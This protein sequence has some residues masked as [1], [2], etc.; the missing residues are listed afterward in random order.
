MPFSS[1]KRLLPTKKKYTQ[2]SLPSKYS[3]LGFWITIASYLYLIPTSV[4][5]TYDKL[6]EYNLDNLTIKEIKHTFQFKSTTYQDT[7]TNT[8]I[9][10]DNTKFN[11]TYPQIDTLINNNYISFINKQL[12]YNILDAYQENL[13]EYNYKYEIGLVTPQLLSIKWYHYTYYYPAPNGNASVFAFNI[14][15]NQKK[16]LEFFDIFDARLNALKNVKK[17]I[18]NKHES[19]NGCAFN[20]TFDNDGF[21]PRF[22]IKDDGIEFIFSEYEASPGMCSSINVFLEHQR[23][24]NY[25]KQDSPLGIFVKTSRT[26]DAT[27]HF[28]NSV[29]SNYEA[30]SIDENTDKFI[31]A[32]K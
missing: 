15:P 21:I 29:M 16:S 19:S 27:N 32:H 31:K 7:I 22:F 26:C 5:W 24:E 10:R 17:M 1:I 12:K 18:K 8:Q 20:D 14:V 13:L 4:L 23:L 28:V 3:A 6:Q 25:Y 30:M 9:K 2:W 11:I